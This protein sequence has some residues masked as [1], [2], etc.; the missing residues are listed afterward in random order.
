MEGWQVAAVGVAALAIDP[1][2]GRAARR[3]KGACAYWLKCSGRSLLART[4]AASTD[5]G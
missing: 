4:S 3:C 1:C 2:C 5:R